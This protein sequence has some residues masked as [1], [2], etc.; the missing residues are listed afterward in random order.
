VDLSGR[1]SGFF[2]QRIGSDQVVLGLSE[3]PVRPNGNAIPHR[4][5]RGKRAEVESRDVIH[6]ACVKVEEDGRGKTGPE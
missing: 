1:P 2:P 3:A 5:R 6:D 4:R